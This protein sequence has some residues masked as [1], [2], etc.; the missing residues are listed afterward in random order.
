MCVFVKADNSFPFCWQVGLI[1]DSRYIHLQILCKNIIQVQKSECSNFQ[2]PSF[3]GRVHRGAIVGL[4]T[5]PP[6]KRAHPKKIEEKMTI[7]EAKMTIF[8]AKMTKL[9]IKQFS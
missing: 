5:T 7:F 1:T 2:H 8:E 6:P 3:Q 4:V 9:F